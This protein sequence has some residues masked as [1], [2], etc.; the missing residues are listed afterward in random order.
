MRPIK[1]ELQAF[2]PFKDKVVIDFS[3][4][5]QEGLFL[6]TG[7]TGS[8]KTTIFDAI[9][10]ALYGQLS[11]SDRKSLGQPTKSQ[12]ASEETLSYVEFEFESKNKT[13]TVYR[14]P[15]Q[16]A[17]GT[18]GRIV[19]H[20]STARLSSDNLALSKITEVQ[21]EINTIL[22]LTATQFKQIVLLPQGEFKDLLVAGS[23][24]K[25]GI[26]RDLFKT[27]DF[28]IFTEKLKLETDKLSKQLESSQN[29]ILAFL[30]VLN[31]D[32]AD[33]NSYLGSKQYDKVVD[34][35]KE[36]IS[37]LK[38][39]V[40]KEQEELDILTKKFNTLIQQIDLQNDLH[41]YQ[42]RKL[43]LDSKREE[44]NNLKVLNTKI[45][46][47]IAL[48]KMLNQIDTLKLKL[49]KNKKDKQEM[50]SQLLNLDSEL[51]NLNNSLE[52]INKDFNHIEEWES[53]RNQ[54][55]Q[56]HLKFS[57]LLEKSNAKEKLII[58]NKQSDENISIG[59]EKLE[60]TNRQLQEKKVQIEK[61]KDAEKQLKQ[62]SQEL[63]E[64]NEKLLISKQKLN[65]SEIVT[66][67]IDDINS[68]TLIF[69]ELKEEKE[70]IDLLVTQREILRQQQIAGVIAQSL[71]E[72]EPCPVCGSLHHPYKAH[73][74]TD[75]ISE[76]SIK[77]LKQEQSTKQSEFAQ[78]SQ[79][80]KSFNESKNKKLEALG[81]SEE[82]FNEDYNHLMKETEHLIKEKQVR[83]DEIIHLKQIISNGEWLEKE[84]DKLNEQLVNNR[85]EINK[86][87]TNKS[88][89][90]E[91][92]NNLDKILNNEVLLTAEDLESLVKDVEVINNKIKVTRLNRD[93][94]S[95]ELNLLDKKK[96]ETVTSLKNLEEMSSTIKIELE[97][98]S[99]IYKDE[100]VAKNIDE[101]EVIERIVTKEDIEANLKTIETYNNEVHLNAGLIK[102]T[103]DR[104][105]QLKEIVENPHTIRLEL[106]NNIR[107]Y[108]TKLNQKN[109]RLSN[110]EATVTEVEQ[111]SGKSQELL[112]QHKEIYPL[113]LAATGDSSVGYL[114]FERY[115]LAS[116]FEEVLEYANERLL[117]MTQDRFYLVV[118]EDK[119][120]R[121][122]ASGLDLEVF[123]NH[124]SRSRSVKTLSGGETFKASLALALGLSDVTSQKYGGV[125]IDA[126]F[127][128]EGFGTLDEQSLDQAIETLL[129]I[130]QDGRIVGII[131]HV[132]EL[133]ERIS[134]Q[135]QVDKSQEGSTI[136]IR[137]Q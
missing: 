99:H 53:E 36:E 63:T 58:L 117:S 102:G 33:F 112:N 114:S 20:E 122:R 34:Y 111:E 125:H 56:K 49:S 82:S 46:D 131:S 7:P 31:I 39:E 97:E 94:T 45:E 42:K 75:E 70:E 10:Y 27:Q 32:D 98:L 25:E 67:T 134:N 96:V 28:Q 104:L 87:E 24:E 110:Y 8:G 23:S 108:T 95:Q 44:I 128:D 62:I 2:G 77:L 69:N 18:R 93:K 73:L 9:F 19:N 107:N 59:K 15:A 47:I 132:K 124:T 37:D 21:A 81:F 91:E 135:I 1:L 57:N 103:N 115:V 83:D 41:K 92:I 89:R 74:S 137:Q 113:Y 85:L 116:F 64:I 16:K 109:N 11:S 13:Y 129:K 84:R 65:E 76:E 127:I 123:D 40:N 72:N 130:N 119:L 71:N 55:N 35:L 51:S 68:E 78:S 100:L 118:M 126:L 121:Q 52:L 88:N 6:I 3:Q 30:R 136:T 48:K 106:E 43:E 38:T 66:R 17:I 14:H 90:L 61:I 86:E 120:A 26:F 60:E 54:I 22:G 29:N 101:S 12:F 50:S 80:L 5:T 79:R 4:F 105:S 133:K